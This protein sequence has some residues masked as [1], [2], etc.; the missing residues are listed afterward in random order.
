[1]NLLHRG[2]K[3]RLQSSSQ[4]PTSSI[5]RFVSLDQYKQVICSRGCRAMFD[6]TMCRAIV[7]TC[8]CGILRANC[9]GTY[10]CDSFECHCDWGGS[11]LRRHQRLAPGETWKTTA[12]MKG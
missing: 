6:V 4:A 11:L 10:H 3:M 12:S 9:G 2:D 7:M 5:H 1:M 8:G